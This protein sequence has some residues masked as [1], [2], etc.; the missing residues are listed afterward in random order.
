MELGVFTQWLNASSVEELAAEVR[1]LQLHCVVLDSYPGLT[2]D[3]NRPHPDDG[4]RIRDAFRRSGV[5]IAAVGGYSN[6]VHRNSE[7]RKAIH[8]RFTG[9][10]ELCEMIE[11]PMLCSESGTYHPV[12]DWAWDPSNLTT[13][14]YENLVNVVGELAHIA[15]KRGVTLGLEPYVMSI[16]YNADVAAR[17]VKD[18]G[19]NN[20]KLVFDPAGLLTSATIPF[21]EEI[22]TQAFDLMAPY[23]GLVHVEDCRPNDQDHFDWL[24][25]GQG[26]IHY[27]TFMNLVTKAGYDGALI[28]EHLS[29]EDV[30]EARSYVLKH[31]NESQSAAKR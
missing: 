27:P 25:A 16:A 10:L 23:I 1:D 6:L 12:D 8:L 31:W 21:Q 11:S 7:Q 19:L 22:L 13:Q 24:A 17:L 14:A 28:L 2:V 4:K 26:L 18:V 29:P 30:G 5:S 20:V 9:L 3:F 15:A